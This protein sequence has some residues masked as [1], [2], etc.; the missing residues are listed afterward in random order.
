[1]D[2]ETEA[3]RSQVSDFPKTTQL[4]SGR[5][6]T[7]KQAQ[8]HLRFCSHP[9]TLW[10]LCEGQEPQ[11]EGTQVLPFIRLGSTLFSPL[12]TWMTLDNLLTP[13]MSSVFFL[14]RS[15]S[16][17]H[18]P[19]C[20]L[21]VLVDSINMQSACVSAGTMLD[22]GPQ[23]LLRQSSCHHGATIFMRRDLKGKEPG[24]QNPG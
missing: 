17:A 14:W 19:Q 3:S 23:Q 18:I 11:G 4:V 8:P 5:D 6:R 7:G 13:A 1:M 9:C 10:P 24:P 22:L 16:P 12:T 2:K 15:P 21:A 20:L